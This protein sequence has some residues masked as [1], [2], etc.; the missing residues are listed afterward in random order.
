MHVF[1]KTPLAAILEFPK[2]AINSWTGDGSIVQIRDGS[3]CG[4]SNSPRN[5]NVCIAAIICAYCYHVPPTRSQSNQ[6]GNR[7][8]H[9]QWRNNQIL[10]PRW[11]KGYSRKQVTTCGLWSQEIN[12]RPRANQQRYRP[13]DKLTG[14]KFHDML[15]FS[16]LRD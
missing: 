14:L 7:V 13:V 5:V 10:H 2:S 8:S 1:L 12:A 3:T 11:F 6:L 15:L 9:G 4:G 16:G